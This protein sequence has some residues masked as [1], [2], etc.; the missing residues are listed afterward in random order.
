MASSSGHVIASGDQRSSST[1]PVISAI[2]Q[3]GDWK[4]TPAHFEATC[5]RTNVPIRLATVWNS[6]GGASCEKALL[7]GRL[8]RDVRELVAD[9]PSELVPSGWCVG[10]LLDLAREARG[11][12]D[13]FLREHS[14]CRGNRDSDSPNR[15][16]RSTTSLVRGMASRKIRGSNPFGADKMP[17][18][19]NRHGA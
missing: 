2:S 4:D 15:W 18:E 10:Q 5:E 1:V 17:A 11:Q 16:H 8:D 12:R 6:V 7:C 3:A 19:G 14:Q 13:V 9:T